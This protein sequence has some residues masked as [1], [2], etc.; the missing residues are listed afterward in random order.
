MDVPVS[1]AVA[2]GEMRDLSRFLA[3]DPLHARVRVINGPER[4]AGQGSRLVIEHRFLGIGPDRVGRVLRWREGSGFAISDLSKRGGDV[5]FPHV[6]SYDLT[7]IGPD[8]CR[9]D[10]STRGRWTAIRVPRLL[11]WFWL[12]WIANETRL[13]LQRW[14]REI[15]Q[16]RGR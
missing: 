8:R 14:A 13:D 4:H 7:P 15:G 11:A 16:G 5:G 2:W 12:W 10:I 3:I 6:I 9:L 1:V